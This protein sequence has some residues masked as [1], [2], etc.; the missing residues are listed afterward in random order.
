ML[1][2][3]GGFLAQKRHGAGP[4][5][6]LC[7]GGAAAAGLRCGARGGGACH[8]L[9]AGGAAPGGAHRAA[10][11]GGDPA[12]RGG[13]AHAASADLGSLRRPS[14]DDEVA[15]DA[16][17]RA[18]EGIAVRDHVYVGGRPLGYVRDWEA[19]RERLRG[20]IADTRPTW[21]SGGTLGAELTIRRQYTRE[22]YVTPLGDMLLLITGAAPVFYYDGTGRFAR[23]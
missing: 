14:E 13:T 21:A 22:G 19:L 11:R 10:D 12:G 7:G 9:L 23:A 18:T 15:T 5:A 1:T 17:L 4:R 6:A 16:L 2:A 8:R 3:G 20:F